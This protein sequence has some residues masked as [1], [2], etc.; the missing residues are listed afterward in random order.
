MPFATAT[1]M[2]DRYDSETLG[3]LVTDNE[4]SLSE[5]EL[6]SS[7]KMT[8]ALAGATGDVIAACLRGERYTRADLDGLTGD[9]LAY[10]KDI[11]CA[12]AFWR[13]WK[14][15]PYLGS[16]DDRRQSA[17]EDYREALDMLNRGDRVFDIDTAQQA[18]RPR[19]ETV[20]HAEI[21][22][23]WSLITDIARHGRFYPRRRTYSNR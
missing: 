4:D 22:D 14:R 18:G 16:M 8:T 3:D 17:Q 7:S 23:R 1:D 2:V 15:K 10:L 20:T 12:F 6:L 11:T 19:I 9:S 5:S 13:L 21:N